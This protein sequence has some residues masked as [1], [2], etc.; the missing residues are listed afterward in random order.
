M[1]PGWAAPSPPDDLQL[2]AALRLVRSFRGGFCLLLGSCVHRGGLSGGQHISFL[3][4]E[5]VVALRWAFHGGFAAICFRGS[6]VRAAER[7]CEV[8]IC[9]DKKGNVG[10]ASAWAPCKGWVRSGQAKLR[11]E[12]SG[13]WVVTPLLTECWQSAAGPA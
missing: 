9:K 3:L 1:F 11:A 4:V 2:C 5:G 10:S 8:P 6:G 7:V 13:H 12:D